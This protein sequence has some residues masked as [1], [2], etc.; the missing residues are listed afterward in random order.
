MAFGMIGSTHNFVFREKK[1]HQEGAASYV[2]L[3]NWF[4]VAFSKC[5]VYALC[6]QI[7]D[8]G[9]STRVF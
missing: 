4:F 1:Q 2:S 6:E 3:H 8:S 7:P 5:L 9:I